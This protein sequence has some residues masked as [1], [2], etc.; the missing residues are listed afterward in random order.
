MSSRLIVL[1]EWVLH[2]LAGEKG[3]ERQRQAGSLLD[4]FGAE[5]SMLAVWR[6]SPW[7]SKFARF[8]NRAARPRPRLLLKK[9]ANLLYDSARCHILE[10]DQV[11]PLAPELAAKLPRKDI[12]LVETYRAAKA[13]LLVTEDARLL[14]ALHAHCP[15]VTV[16]TR[17]D[18]MRALGVC[19]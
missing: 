18:F 7:M 8:T 6:G 17:D 12:Y 19:P 10:N 2:D 1:N 13:D 5:S 16:Q 9:L 11:P 4:K 14:A 15:D 3:E